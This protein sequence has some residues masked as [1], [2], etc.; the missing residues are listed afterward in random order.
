MF[1]SPLKAIATMMHS[2]SRAQPANTQLKEIIDSMNIIY[3]DL[4]IQTG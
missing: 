1:Q 3:N 2:E 4:R